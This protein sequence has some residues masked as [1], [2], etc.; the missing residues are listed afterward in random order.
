MKFL[1]NQAIQ[2]LALNGKRIPHIIF[3]FR[4]SKYIDDV[5]FQTR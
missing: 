1:K 2:I 3:V 4:G 5:Q